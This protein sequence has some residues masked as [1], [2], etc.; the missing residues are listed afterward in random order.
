MLHTEKNH[1]SKNDPALQRKTEKFFV[2]EEKTLI[3]SATD[4]IVH[5]SSTIVIIFMLALLVTAGKSQ[6]HLTFIFSLKKV[7]KL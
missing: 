2:S 1:L 7:I 6:K 5:D 3:G 4:P